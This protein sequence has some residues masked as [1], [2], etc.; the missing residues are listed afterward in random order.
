[1]EKEILPKL[2]KNNPIEVKTGVTKIKEFIG[3]MKSNMKLV[4]T[5]SN[6]FLKGICLKDRLPVKIKP[7][8]A[9]ITNLKL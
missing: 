6:N 3:F 5:I 7:I 4:N 2:L 1:M 9:R 8:K